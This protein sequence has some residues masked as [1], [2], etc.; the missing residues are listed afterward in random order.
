MDSETAVAGHKW[1]RERVS[2]VRWRL[3]VP[4]HHASHSEVSERIL[5]FS[6]ILIFGFDL[7]VLE[8]EPKPHTF[9]IDSLPRSHIPAPG[10]AFLG[11]GDR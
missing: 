9:K 1:V 10:F 4:T 8:L 7:G 6:H 2:D 11:R 5:D 3:P